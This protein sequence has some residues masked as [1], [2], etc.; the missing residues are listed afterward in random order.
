MALLRRATAM[1][2][3]YGNIL[4]IARHPCPKLI[5]SLPTGWKG[6][7]AAGGS[8]AMGDIDL[9]ERIRL[10]AHEIWASE[11]RPHGRDKIHWLRAE[12]EIRDKL[13]APAP[14]P[15]KSRKKPSRKSTPTTAVR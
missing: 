15:E 13:K 2:I 5:T 9:T 6:A 10:R 3:P 8:L 11:G 12:A 14:A 7:E 1:T 4:A